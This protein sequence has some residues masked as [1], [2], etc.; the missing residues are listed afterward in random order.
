MI[1][2]EVNSQ[3]ISIVSLPSFAKKKLILT[4]SDVGRPKKEQIQ[5]AE[6]EPHSLGGMMRLKNQHFIPLFYLTV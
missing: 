5:R 6:L 4:L 1:V 2:T 3:V